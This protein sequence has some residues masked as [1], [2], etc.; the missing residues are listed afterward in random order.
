MPSFLFTFNLKKDMNP[1]QLKQRIDF[2]NDLTRN[3]RFTFTEYAIAVN[4]VVREFILE[5]LGDKE[6]RNPKNFQW[7][8]RINDQLYNLIKTSTPALVPGTAITNKYYT[9][10]VSTLAFPNDYSDFVGLNLIINGLTVYG[11]PTSFNKLQPMLRDSF[12]HPTDDNV[13]YNWNATGLTIYYNGTAS[14]ASLVYI[15][16]PVNYSIGQEANLIDGPILL[17]AGSYY[18]TAPSVYNGVSYQIG[19][20][21]TG[22]FTLSS[23]QVILVS[24]TSPVDLADQVHEEI[25][26]RASVKMLIASGN[27]PSAQAVQTEAAKSV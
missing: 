19:D 9:T 4:D 7:I 10:K 5:N 2:Y 24:V 13:F 25:A 23:G 18:A 6:N 27:Y 20:V 11:R 15:K 3:A 17:S 14:S 1:I 8:D 26:K 21:I 16:D 22:G 12:R